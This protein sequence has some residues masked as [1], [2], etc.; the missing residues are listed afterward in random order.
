MGQSGRSIAGELAGNSPISQAILLIDL[1]LRLFY[2][3]T[4]LSGYYSPA[5]NFFIATIQIGVIVQVCYTPHLWCVTYTYEVMT[6][7]LCVC[8][9]PF[10]FQ[11]DEGGNVKQ[12]ILL[13]WPNDIY[14]FILWVIREVHSLVL[15]NMCNLGWIWLYQ[16][17]WS[18]LCP[19][20]Q[21]NI[22]HQPQNSC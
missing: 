5:S 3:L 12:D 7:D 13:V 14:V 8:F 18:P 4:Y 19:T 22:L 16:P 17:W 9:S 11:N 2:L 21:T 10:W 15:H 20:T 6:F 1:P